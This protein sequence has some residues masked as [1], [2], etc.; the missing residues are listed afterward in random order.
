M[1]DEPRVLRGPAGPLAGRMPVPSSK[2]L[3]NRALIVA[4]AARGGM[5]FDALDCG[6]TR[7]LAEALATAGWA[8]DWRG[9][10][11]T[12]GRRRRL[13]SVV[14][15]DLGDSGTG[16]RSIL[17]LLATT[18]GHFIVDGSDR[19]RRRPMEPLVRALRSLGARI[20]AAG[21]WQLPISVEGAPLAGGEIE[22]RPGVSSQFVTA[23]LMAA[24]LFR[25]GLI[26][27]VEGPIPSV[28]YLDLTKRMLQDFGAEVESSADRRLWSVRPGGLTP[29]RRR[30]EGD[31]SAAAFPIAA[32]GVAGGWVQVPGLDRE[33]VQ[34]DRLVCEILADAGMTFEWFGDRLV[35]R[36]PITRPIVADLGATPDTFPA[37][38]A[39]AAVRSPGSRLIGLEHLIHKESSRL[40]AMTDNLRLLGASLTMDRGSFEVEATV[41][42]TEGPPRP[43]RA[44]GDHRIAMAMAVAA[45]EAGPLE[46]DEPE[47][48][49]K[50]FP[51]FWNLWEHLIEGET[52]GG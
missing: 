46:L 18:P 6:D 11:I 31:W 22:I 32:A 38:A 4:A 51:G 24:P 13:D 47:T 8:V 16:A 1:A 52:E 45:L 26:L 29:T 34:G 2:S 27:H 41:T 50:S 3:T 28:P 14:R 25:R 23:L 7:I 20:E 43:V 39:L 44:V 40:E 21:G 42:R 36:G 19:L 49:V 30:I 12:I 37:L 17:A 5:V 48:V 10:T 33:S 35:A 15:L 9:T